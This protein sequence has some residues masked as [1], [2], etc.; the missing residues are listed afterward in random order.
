LSPEN[1]KTPTRMTNLRRSSF[2][3]ARHE[4]PVGQIV[5]DDHTSPKT[6]AWR[7]HLYLLT[8]AALLPAFVGIY[9]LSFWLR[10]EGQLSNCGLACFHATVAWVVLA[11]LAWFAGLRTCRG[12]SR[13]VTFY[14]LVILLRAATGGLLTMAMIQCFLAP[15]PIIPRSVFLLDWGTTIVVLGGARALLRGVRETRWR[16]FSSADQ[17]RV[18]IAGAGDMGESTLRLIRRIDQPHYHVVGFIGDCPSLVGTRIEGVPVVGVCEHTRQLVQR[19]GVRQILVMQGELAGAQLRQL[20]GDARRGGCE[21]RVLPD[22]RQLIAGSMTVQPRPVSIED[23]LQR[24]PVQLDSG[25]IRQW[26]D[27]RVI[28]VTGSAGSIGSEICRQLLRFAPQRIVMLDRAET[29][30]F[31]LE[32]ELR[33]L[34]GEKQIDV[35]VADVLD[36]PRLRRILMQYRPHVIFHAAAYKHVPLMEH[37]PQEAVRNIVTAT[38]QLADLALEFRTDS[39]VMISTDKA[40]NPTSVM[41]ACKRVAEMYV[42]S[43]AGRSSTR[44]VTVRFGNV[45]DSAGSVVQL[46]R[47]QIAAGG[48][49]TV[50]DPEMRRYFMTIPE[51]SRLVLQAGAIGQS[52]QILL[53]DMGEPVR[54]VDLAADMIRLSGLRVG[55][56]VAIEFTGLRPGEKLYEELHIPGEQ[57]LPT[58]HP[59]II[60]AEHKPGRVNDIHGAIDELE[61]SARET[62]DAIID[63]L[64]QIVCGY[65]QKQAPVAQRRAAA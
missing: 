31:F 47:Q 44:F 34:A 11:K 59:K 32:R 24:K 48:P 3:D 38:R 65:R 27:G 7:R 14:D 13:S 12:W 49:V 22:Y 1:G 64:Q 42:Q 36:G 30:Q 51:A 6:D 33:P 56:D 63:Q 40:V 55:D 26:L 5:N 21:V 41:G 9:Y 18:L 35:C 23:L 16:L 10:F 25:E 52:G 43:L 15:A 61:Q 8:T 62:P 58:R 37:H 53:L 19:H 57:V 28:L 46:F 4:Q 2:L 39:L 20:I 54:I 45:L 17:V 50:T 60:V 29:G